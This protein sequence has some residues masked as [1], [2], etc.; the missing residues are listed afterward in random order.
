MDPKK[1][2]MGLIII[3]SSV[4]M[5]RLTILK[6]RLTINLNRRTPLYGHHKT[7]RPGEEM[8]NMDATFA[9]LIREEGAPGL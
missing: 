8:P 4:L 6:I 9:V 3:D 1:A 7:I 5:I 2:R